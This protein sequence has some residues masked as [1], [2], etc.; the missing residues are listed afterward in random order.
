MGQLVRARA[1][2]VTNQGGHIDATD[3][4]KVKVK[5]PSPNSCENYVRNSIRGF[6]KEGIPK[7]TIKATR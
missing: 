7:I 6:R 4:E 1:A 5:T 3:M 2:G